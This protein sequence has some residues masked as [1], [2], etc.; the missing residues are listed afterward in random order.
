MNSKL[1][2][3]LFLCAAFYALTMSAQLTIDGKRPVYDSRSNT[4]LLTLPDTVFG[5]N[6][7]APA[8]VDDTVGWVS[9]N[10]LQ[11]RDNVAFP[12]VNGEVDYKMVY[13]AG[14]KVKTAILRFTYLPI[15]SL[16]GEFSDTYTLGDLQMTMP[17]SHE[18][19]QYKVRVKWAGGIQVNKHNFHLKFVD[20]NLE[21]LDVSFFGLRNDNH[22]RLDAGNADMLRIRNKT[23]HSLWASFGTKS[24]YADK[25]SGAR[26]YVRGEHVEMF[27]NGVYDGFFD[28]AEYLDR[29]QMK[30][31]KYDDAL[32]V[33]HGLMWKA[34]EGNDYT[35]FNKSFVV[36]NYAENCGGFDV[37]YPDI[38]EVCPTNY[39]VLNNAARFV[40]LSN[41]NM[42]KSQV[43]N[44]FDLPVLIDY[45]VFMQTLFAIDNTSKNIVW[46]CYDSAVDNKLTLS[47]WDLDAT[48]GQTWYDGPG[49]YHADEIQPENDMDSIPLKFTLLSKSRLWKRL[50]E[51]P[52]F[53]W[54]ATNRYW[55]LR[56]TA[57]D[58]DSIIAKYET[59]FRNLEN[60]GALERESE[61][62]SRGSDIANRE[63][64]FNGEFD[65]LCDWIRRRIAYMDTHTFACLR[66]DVNG[67]GEVNIKDVTILLN[68]LLLGDREINLI[69]AD[70][71]MDSS[72]GIG[73]LTAIIN[74]ILKG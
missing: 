14:N 6:F 47:V 1:S 72:I 26:S 66:G 8:V 50:R 62:W 36:D 53:N 12:V 23:A 32:G 7:T 13:L 22:W 5:K 28:M 67:D 15:L 59:I 43:G 46:G 65:Y 64:D 20:D 24:Y 27:L 3:L 55:T 18:T 38:D 34:K 54:R 42:F 31:K 41:D 40:V 10:G 73:D 45:Y 48:A 68:Y 58:P 57:L 30:L 71:D 44:F 2:F 56:Q 61:R 39:Y 9:I 60:A 70:A 51:L 16:N 19:L 29:K 33:F 69:N 21:K 63:L 17:D 4:F 37:M 74:I 52:D 25:Q 49:F 11:V 35:L